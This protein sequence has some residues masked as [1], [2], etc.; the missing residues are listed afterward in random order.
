LHWKV[1]GEDLLHWKENEDSVLD[2]EDHPGW[3]SLWCHSSAVS[4]CSDW[5]RGAEPDYQQ[6]TR[7]SP[8]HQTLARQHRPGEPA[9]EKEAGPVLA[10]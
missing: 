8:Q 10:H 6:P 4:T 5:W 2:K 7:A 1:E 9:Q 3:P